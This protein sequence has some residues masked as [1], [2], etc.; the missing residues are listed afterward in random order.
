MTI[1]PEH[2]DLHRPVGR[3]DPLADEPV[4]ERC[5]GGL[6]PDYRPAPIVTEVA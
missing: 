6:R 3:L 4:R 1:S 5:S 2:A